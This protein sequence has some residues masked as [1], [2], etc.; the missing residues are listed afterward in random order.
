MA[1]KGHRRARPAILGLAALAALAASAGAALSGQL[2]TSPAGVLVA[3]HG[4]VSR[5]D[6]RTLALSPVA[7]APRGVSEVAATAR[8]DWLAGRAKDGR[9]VV[10]IRADA[11]GQG[12]RVRIP[13][14]VDVLEE[15]ASGRADWIVAVTEKHAFRLY[16]IDDATLSA[17]PVGL[18]G[19]HPF[20]I[21]ADDGGVWAL[22]MLGGS[23]VRVDQA[24]RVVARVPISGTTTA[25]TSVPGGALVGTQDGQIVRVAGGRVVARARDGGV[26][27]RLAAGGG[28]AY[29]ASLSS[30]SARTVCWTF[31]RLD[32]L[33]LSVERKRQICGPAEFIVG[34]LVVSGRD[35]WA[36]ESPASNR[37]RLRR[38][39]ALTLA[40]RGLAP[41]K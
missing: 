21:T 13:G 3:S 22:G 27:Y 28:A 39:D 6:P 30:H 20:G 14:V 23:L 40:Q 25:L 17:T 38:L 5:V 11:S 35:L 37:Y 19:L 16:R 7:G 10:V 26:P 8:A 4:I 32:P 34:E 29:A 41:V 36:L 1:R 12:P 9:S 18:G 31:T 33:R 24:G 2:T 15:V